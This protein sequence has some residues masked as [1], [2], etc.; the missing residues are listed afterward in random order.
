M[1]TRGAGLV[2][3]DEPHTIFW[4]LISTRD[5]RAVLLKNEGLVVHEAVVRGFFGCIFVIFQ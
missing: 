1:L 3:V 2:A 5:P 4:S